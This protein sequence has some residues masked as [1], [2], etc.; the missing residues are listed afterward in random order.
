[1]VT[2]AGEAGDESL[3]HVASL[4]SLGSP[5]WEHVTTLARHLIT[6]SISSDQKDDPGNE[7]QKAERSLLER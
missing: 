6:T 4:L 7:I 1:M 3:N 5:V 2:F